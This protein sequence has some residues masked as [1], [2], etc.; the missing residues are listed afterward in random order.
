MPRA[1][2]FAALAFAA[3]TGFSPAGPPSSPTRA[4]LEKLGPLAGEWKGSGTAKAGADKLWAETL[5]VNF[6]FDGDDA[7]LVLSVEN[8]KRTK[9]G[10][11]RYDPKSKKYALTLTDLDDKETKYDGELVKG[12]FVAT[13]KDAATGDVTKLTLY[14]LA[15]G[16]RLVMKAER[17]AKGKGPASELYSV[18]ATRAGAGFAG[19]AKKPECVVT[20]GLGTIAVQVEGKTVYVCCSGCR[21]EVLAN[22]KKYA[23]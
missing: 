3:L 7:W 21:D 10:E 5:S 6:K 22:P 13:S 20:G 8:G 2:A 17:Q 4:A 1:L 12:N 9:S 18:A 19:G 16:A 14:T 15:D 11:L 23:K